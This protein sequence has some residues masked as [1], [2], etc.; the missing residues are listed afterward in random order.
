MKQ[1]PTQ[2][3]EANQF[4]K[5]AASLLP[6]PQPRSIEQYHQSSHWTKE[7]RVCFIAGLTWYRDRAQ[8]VSGT[9]DQSG[10]RHSTSQ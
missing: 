9:E 5:R 2:R 7:G 10:L 4:I 1:L 8:E 6:S 3:K